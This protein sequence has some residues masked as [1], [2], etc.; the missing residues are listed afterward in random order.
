MTRQVQAVWVSLR[1]LWLYLQ[2]ALL[3]PR[4]LASPFSP[5]LS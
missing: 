4:S 2:V 3:Q 5:S 1:S